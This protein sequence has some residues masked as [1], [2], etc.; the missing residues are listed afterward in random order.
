M[1]AGPMEGRQHRLALCAGVAGGRNFILFPEGGPEAYR[2]ACNVAPCF[3]R[4]VGSARVQLALRW[5]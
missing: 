2:G 4:G 5:C 3:G 1:L